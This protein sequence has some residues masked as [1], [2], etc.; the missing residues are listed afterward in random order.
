M[1]GIRTVCL[2]GF[3]ALHAALASHATSCGFA[4]VQDAQSGVFSSIEWFEN[5]A[6]HGLAQPDGQPPQLRLLLATDRQTGHAACL[7]MLHG[8]HWASLSNYYSGLFD[9]IRWSPQASGSD[10]T[11]G[12]AAAGPVSPQLANK[13]SL[14]LDADTLLEQALVHAMRQHLPQHQTVTFSPLDSGATFTAALE[15]GLQQT[16]FR[17][18]RYFVFANWY[19]DVGTTTWGAYFGAL[20]PPLRNGIERGRRRLAKFA[21]SLRIQQTVDDQLEPSIQ[22]FVSV[23]NQSWKSPEPNPGFIPNLIRLAAA[24]GWLRLGILQLGGQPIA[25]Q[26]WLV[27]HRKAYIFKLAYV[28]GHERFSP[29]SVLTSGLMEHVLDTDKVSQVD[30]L[31]GDDAY[32]KDWMSHRRERIG[33]VAFDKQSLG[34]NWQALRHF[35]H[36][37]V[38]QLR[39]SVV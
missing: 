35:T 20:P 24:L 2:P 39:K 26:L 23:Y 8:L 15:A 13:P 17:V 6:R 28:K 32:K 5:L 37:Y 27:H 11:T 9:V 36:Q 31:S 30:Y 1:S 18:G 3:E 16:G 4:L 14:K 7:P 38:Q 25:A 34:G 10:A 22:H 33:L 21:W 19:L 12:L 29:G